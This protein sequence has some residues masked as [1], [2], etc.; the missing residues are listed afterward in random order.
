MKRKKELMRKVWE[1]DLC[2]GSAKPRSV[3][4]PETGRG[5]SKCLG[6]SIPVDS[7]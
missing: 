1:G 5:G 4:R 3:G 2:V 6:K 7:H